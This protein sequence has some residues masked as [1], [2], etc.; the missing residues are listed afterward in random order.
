MERSSEAIEEIVRKLE[1]E[2]RIILSEVK[3]KRKHLE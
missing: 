1:E 2:Q 3:E